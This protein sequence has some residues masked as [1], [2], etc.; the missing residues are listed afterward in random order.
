MHENDISRLVI[1]CAIEVH[2]IR[3]PGLLES[4]YEECLSAEMK[5]NRL[6]FERQQPIPLTYRGMRLDCGYRVDFV[7]ED[8]VVMELKAVEAITPVMEAVALIPPS[9]G[10]AARPADELSCKSNGQGIASDC[11]Q[12]LEPR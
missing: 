5:A 8:K 12:A 6:S 1:G 2:K 3:G 7:I 9:S 11:K 4:V 10:Q